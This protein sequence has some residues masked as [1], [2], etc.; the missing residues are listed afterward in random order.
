[1]RALKIDVPKPTFK[2]KNCPGPDCHAH[3]TIG[4]VW[5]Y[6]KVRCSEC[7]RM[8][9]HLSGRFYLV[10]DEPHQTKHQPPTKEQS[11]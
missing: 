8:L 11:P 5:G 9:V 2:P 7:Q 6:F 10:E 3:V 4:Y 1:M